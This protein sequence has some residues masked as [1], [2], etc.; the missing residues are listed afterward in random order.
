MEKTAILLYTGVV[1]N[2]DFNNLACIH[3][4]IAHIYP[5]YT[6]K[7]SFSFAFSNLKGREKNTFNYYLLKK[8]HVLVDIMEFK[9]FGRL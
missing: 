6:E 7:S 8:S 9:V 5:K 3:S 4:L 1:I 2:L